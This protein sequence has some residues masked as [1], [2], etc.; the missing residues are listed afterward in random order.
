[1]SDR[2]LDSR[3]FKEDRVPGDPKLSKEQAAE[4]EQIISNSSIVR[5][6]L[7]RIIKEDIAK[8]YEVSE[9]F[10]NPAWERETIAAAAERKALRRY[11]KLIKGDMTNV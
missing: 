2:K 5:E 7:A 4:T 3:W 1:M 10:A 11:L 8:T 9:D 6:R